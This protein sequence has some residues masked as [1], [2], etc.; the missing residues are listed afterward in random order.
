MSAVT[1][2]PS[3]ALGSGYVAELVGDFWDK[4][5]NGDSVCFY[6]RVSGAAG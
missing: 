5:L 2:L 3:T 1:L 6:L 4:R